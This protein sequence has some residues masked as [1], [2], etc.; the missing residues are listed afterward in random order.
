MSSPASDIDDIDA[1]DA[2]V[3]SHADDIW[4]YLRRRAAT[5]ADADD[6]AAEV[7]AI[8][9]RKRAHRLPEQEQRLWL[10]GVA[11]RV[12]ASYRRGQVRGVR[13]LTRLAPTT[14]TSEL[15]DLG[16]RDRVA[17]ALAELPDLDREVLLL[18][19]WDGFAVTDI[20][21]LLDVTPT[22]CRCD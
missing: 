19:A 22:P 3:R 20:A 15:P 1:A 11:R 4:R 10:Y 14:T 17:R 2:L 6:L 21:A 7:F 13:L 12:L 9:W 16:E 5:D 8:A 18:R